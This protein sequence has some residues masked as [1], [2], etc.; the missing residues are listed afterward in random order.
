MRAPATRIGAIACLCL[1][2]S[3]TGTYVALSKPLA[4]VFPVFLL[5]WL[6]FGIGAVAMLGWLR[7]PA[8]EAP[9]TPQVKTLLFLNAF[10]GSFVFTLLMIQGVSLTNATTAGV[11]MAFIP[12][13]VALMSWIFLGERIGRRTW[14]AVACAVT[15]IALYS[16]FKPPSGA[17]GLAFSPASG[18]SKFGQVL[19]VAMLIGACFCEATYSVVGKR[20]TAAL[21]PKRISALMNLWGFVLATPAG[22]FV[23]W[24]FDFSA[25]RWTDWA[26]VLFYACAACMWSVWLWM[27]GLA[28]IPASQAGVF[29][30]MLPVSAALIGVALLG[31]AMSGPQAFAFCL[32]LA[33]IVLASLPESRLKRAAPGR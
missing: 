4:L 13:C 20:L 10:L 26:L 14:L 25:V 19:G 15:G 33:S 21:G 23:A 22:L 11:I 1:S 24:H 9:L 3:L 7:R 27:S 8:T 5:A 6:R 16:Y 18:E 12:A 2:M 29:T 28:R 17:A 31:E 32:A 30:V